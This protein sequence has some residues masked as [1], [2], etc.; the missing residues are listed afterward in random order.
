MRRI[1]K[2]I[3]KI[4]KTIL[5]IL[6]GFIVGAGLFAVLTKYKVPEINYSF[7]GNNPFAIKRDIID[8]VLVWYFTI[9]ALSGLIL[10]LISLVCDNNILHERKYNTKFYLRFSIVMLFL[11]FLCVPTIGNFG[12]YTAK[13]KW[14]PMIIQNQKEIFLQSKHIIEHDGLSED[15]I[16]QKNLLGDVEKYRRIN[17]ES[18][19]KKISQIEK[20]LEVKKRFTQLEDRIKYLER[21][22]K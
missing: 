16:K 2:I 10:R 12:R 9:F 20:L 5:N 1:N 7:Y 15:Q 4:D 8:G 17:Y 22:Y 18:T 3:K 6:S 21:Y 11:I 14:F 13:R 19:E